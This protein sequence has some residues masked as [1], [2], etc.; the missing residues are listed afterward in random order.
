M[1]IRVYTNVINAETGEHEKKL[2]A[3]YTEE[4]WRKFKGS[5]RDGGESRWIDATSLNSSTTGAGPLA[6]S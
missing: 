2:I 4:N 3:E 1:M 5:Q 6:S